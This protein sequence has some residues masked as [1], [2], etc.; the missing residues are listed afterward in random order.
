MYNDYMILLPDEVAVAVLDLAEA[1]TNPTTPEQI[2]FNLRVAAYLL[3]E[4]YTA[5]EEAEVDP[6]EVER[7]DIPLLV[8]GSKAGTWQDGVWVPD[9]E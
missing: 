1:M 9:N 5:F 3:P 2:A 7:P 6:D 4:M 8:V